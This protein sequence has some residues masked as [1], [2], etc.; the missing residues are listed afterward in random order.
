MA[1]KPLLPNW[2]S[3]SL[4]PN[5]SVGLQIS[6]QVGGVERVFLYPLTGPTWWVVKPTGLPSC[7]QPTSLISPVSTPMVLIPRKC[8]SLLSKRDLQ[9]CCSVS[10]LT[11]HLGTY[12]AGCQLLTHQVF[13]LSGSSC[14]AEDSSHSQMSFKFPVY[15]KYLI[16]VRSLIKW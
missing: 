16:F 4:G 8:L 9:E 5:P 10:Y 3:N 2:S 13:P 12:S 1:T 11:T 6:D 7:S 14:C 15:C